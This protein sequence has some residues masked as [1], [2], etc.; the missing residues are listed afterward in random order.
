VIAPKAATR[1]VILQGSPSRTSW[2]VFAAADFDPRPRAWTLRLRRRRRESRAPRARPRGTSPRRRCSGACARSR[3]PPRRCRWARRPTGAPRRA[4]RH[5][6]RATRRYARG[7]QECRAIERRP[8]LDVAEGDAQ[9]AEPSRA[10]RATTSTNARALQGACT[11]AR[12][13]KVG[14]CDD[15]HERSRF[16]ARPDHRT[17]PAAPRAM[18]VP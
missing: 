4:R 5:P 3:A 10:T 9:R 11:G 7:A 13:P 14:R 17:E 2:R 16:A 15:F 1:S 18:V 12:R 6:A 8:L